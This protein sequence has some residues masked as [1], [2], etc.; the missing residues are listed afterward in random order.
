MKSLTVKDII[1]VCDGKLICGNEE[2]V[3]E[4]FSKDTRQINEGDVYVGIKG[5]KFDG[6]LFYEEALKQGAK[7]CLLGEIELQ[8]EVYKKYEG[9]TIITVKDTLKALQKL[10]S[11]K[12]S[13]YDIPVVAITG[14]VGKTSTKDMVASVVMQSYHV[15]KTQG[16]YNNQIGLPLTILGLKD[17]TALVVEMGMS[18][19]GEISKLTNIA[20]PNICV[21]TNVGTAHIGNLGSRENILKAKLEILE[22]LSKDGTLVINNDNDLLHKWNMENNT[23]QVIDFGIENQSKVMAKDINLKEYESNFLT[24]IN[25][26]TVEV[27][28]PVSGVHFVYNALCAI[29][30]GET[31]HI[32]KEHILKGIKEFELSKNRMEIIE[33][34]DGVTIINDCYNANFDSMKASIESLSRMNAKQK[35][36]VLGDMLELGEYSKDLHE[37]VGIEVAKNKIDLLITVGKEARNIAKQAIMEGMDQ[38]KIYQL[39]TIEEA[40]RIIKEQSQ[41]GDAILVKASNGMNFKRI[42][43]AI[44]K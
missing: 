30:V 14:S 44:R 20:K 32:S 40:I 37:K 33:N 42:V 10:A 36:A 25:G 16:N 8:E 23:Y 1:T 12:R 28:V 17:H 38:D 19:A 3:C 11:Y 21:I 7:V 13:L 34:K 24:N 22:G 27:T 29:C 31:L 6:S 18:E 4:N 39:E 26:E 15:L 43:E 5:E 41:K 2:Q 9:A 35:I